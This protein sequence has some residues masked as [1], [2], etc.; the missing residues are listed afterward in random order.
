[1]NSCQLWNMKDATSYCLNTPLLLMSCSVKCSE[2]EEDLCAVCVL[3]VYWCEM[4][5]NIV[6]CFFFFQFYHFQIRRTIKLFKYR[7]FCILIS[8]PWA[9]SIEV[10]VYL[11]VCLFDFLDSCSSNRFT[12]GGCIA[13]KQ[14][15]RS[16]EC[17][18]AGWPETVK[19]LRITEFW[20][21]T[22]FPAFEELV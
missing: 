1:M 14:R 12:L 17:V 6:I 19:L 5:M 7:I 16:V 11:Y 9:Y 20:Q 21:S 3:F 10:D 13:D 4:M 22:A 18:A 15:Q 8:L 2:G